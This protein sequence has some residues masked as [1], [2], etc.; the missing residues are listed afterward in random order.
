MLVA[1]DIYSQHIDIAFRKSFAALFHS[2]F[3]AY[4]QHIQRVVKRSNS[5]VTGRGRSG[6]AA[7]FKCNLPPAK[8]KFKTNK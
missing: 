6:F 5:K 1:I 7:R 2:A 3:M 4:S 8:S